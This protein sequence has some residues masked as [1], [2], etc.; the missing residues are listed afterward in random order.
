M[1]ILTG[2]K[3]LLLGGGANEVPLVT[4][5]QELGVY[6]IVADYHSDFQLSPA[7]TIANETW[8][9]SWADLDT[10]E[11]M[12]REA[13]VDG[14]LAG[15]SEL[16][17][18]SMIQL[19]SRLGLPS[20]IT[21]EQ[22]E[23][24]RD[25]IKFKEACRASGVPVV[26]EYSGP[27]EVDKFPVIVKPVDRAGSIGITVATNAAELEKAYAYAMEMSITK[28]VIIEDF[29]SNGLKVDMY[30]QILDGE[31]R[32]LPA[33]DTIFAQDNGTDR[34]VQNGWIIPSVHMDA[35]SRKVDPAM[36]KMIENMRIRNGYIFF[37]GFALENDEFVFFECGFRLCGG[38]F[39]HFWPFYGGW[40]TQD[41]LI[42]HALTGSAEA[43]REE[44]KNDPDM[45]CV[46]VNFDAK[47]GTIG[48]I[49][50]MDEIAKIPAC[51]M[52]LTQARLGE[53]CTDDT[54]ILTKIGMVHFCSHSADELAECVKS[55]YELFRVAGTDG[56]DMLYDRLD[57][58][59]VRH[60]W[61]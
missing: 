14:I 35:F 18:D 24:T 37:S 25:K 15:Y 29:I 17:V 31:I 41:L 36:R 12:C 21:A 20:Y 42:C 23:I 48:K 6:V 43:V 19:C 7:K 61:D 45:K 27:E 4:R 57:P 9:V 49:S 60:W 3:L 32:L 59:I 11:R 50:G 2:K 1:Q 34:V 52:T 5:A 51:K 13:N 47:R 38:H 54:A 10:L 39:Y 53:E 40:D 28:Q 22:L 46:T 55:V 16:R 8:C 44:S 26:H 58:E 30:Y 33:S 56:E